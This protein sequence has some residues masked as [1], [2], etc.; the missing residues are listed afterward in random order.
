MARGGCEAVAV[1]AAGC[2]AV[3]EI[4]TAGGCGAV[5]H[6]DV[7]A[8]GGRRKMNGWWMKRREVDGFYEKYFKE[9]FEKY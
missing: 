8:G 1:L 3:G 6:G 4:W 2:E 5:A 9:C 7:A